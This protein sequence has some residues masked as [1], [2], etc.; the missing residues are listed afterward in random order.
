MIQR[1]LMTV[2]IAAVLLL[3]G[4]ASMTEPERIATRPL[5]KA[6][7]DIVDASSE[8]GYNLLRQVNL[9]DRDKN[10]FISPLSVSMA[11]GMTMNGA[12]GATL[13]SMRQ[14][15]AFAG[16]TEHEINSSYRTLMYLLQGIDP[17]VKFQVANSIWARQG[18]AVERPFVDTNKYYFDAEVRS[19]NFADPS[20]GP[21]INKWVKTNTNG[22]IPKI[23]PEPIPSDV[24]MYLINAIYFKGSWRQKFEPKQTQER[25]FFLPA[26]SIRQIMT[27]HTSG[28]YRYFRNDR[29]EMIDLPYGDSLFSMTVLLPAPGTDINAFVAQ[30]NDSSMR[31][32]TN[33]MHVVNDM[34]IYLPKFKL[35][36]EKTLNNVLQA[37]G[38]ENA[39]SDA[40]DF[41]RI[42]SGGRLFISN[43]KHKTF[44]EVNEEG[45]EAAAATSVEI[46]LDSSMP[47]P[48]MR[49]DRPFV[50]LIRERTSDAILFMGKVLDPS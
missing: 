34:E 47:P 13:D 7:T 8:F 40:A 27:M 28:N 42:N 39:F 45:T 38:M 50:F 9:E 16:L 2:S 4:C 5:T 14:T 41:T 3:T 1:Y 12:S 20:A 37:M 32:W 18:F 11:L 43:V 15:L 30:L 36:Y 29:V 46:T 24:V 19:L 44:V 33:V 25:P 6:E 22:K 21:T 10:V 17:S 31:A 23:V 49:V 35:E 48:A 26:G